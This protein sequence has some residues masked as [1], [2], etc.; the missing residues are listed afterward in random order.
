MAL[1]VEPSRFFLKGKVKYFSTEFLS[2]FLD[3]EYL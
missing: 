2:L 3:D 1:R